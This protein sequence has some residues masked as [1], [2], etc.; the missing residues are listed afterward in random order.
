MKRL[1]RPL[2][3]HPDKFDGPGLLRV[4]RHGDGAS[5]VA[6]ARE[7]ARRP[8]TPAT[9]ALIALLTDPMPGVRR[10][11]ARG[12]GWRGAG[13]EALERAAKQER[14][15]TVALDLAEARVRCGVP[16]AEATPSPLVMETAAGPR[17][18]ERLLGLGLGEPERALARRVAEPLAELRAGLSERARRDDL[19]A[20]Q[21]L[22]ELGEDDGLIETLRP[23]LGKRGENARLLALGLL[24]DPAVLDELLDDLAR[25]D[26]DPGRAFAHR[27]LSAL[28]LGRLGVPDVCKRLVRALEVE[29]LEH[30]GRPGA[31]LGVQYPVRAVLIWALGEVQ[32]PVADLL[33]G[34]LDNTHQSAL[35]GFHLPAMA[36]L[37]K[38]GDL[39]RPA[40]ESAARGSSVAAE[41]AR[42][43]LAHGSS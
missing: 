43:V 33:C 10:A 34:Y 13:A 8:E 38:L 17:D 21:D 41:N 24:G 42:R 23:S 32:A 31:G 28:A 15:S 1:L 14:T 39:A 22:A 16:L 27:R 40:L 12:L 30:E 19:Q 3:R 26:L 6:A 5:R 37:W 20:L 25:M 29:A 9:Q 7:L 11:A 4:L 36:A 35:G 18:P 2:W